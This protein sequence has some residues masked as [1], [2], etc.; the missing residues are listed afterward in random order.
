MR[1]QSMHVS[2]SSNGLC[3]SNGRSRAMCQGVPNPE[4]HK[5]ILEL[6]QLSC[7]WLYFFVTAVVLL[8]LLFHIRGNLYRICS[9]YIDHF[10]VIND[11]LKPERSR[12]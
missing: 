7:W 6:G 2:I 5:A 1:E 4:D 9:I 8:L 10:G 12:S 3:S 11:L